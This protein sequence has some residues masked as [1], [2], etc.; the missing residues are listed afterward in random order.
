MVWKTTCHV[1]NWCLHNDIVTVV[2]ARSARL[3]SVAPDA[4]RGSATATA[5]AT[6]RSLSSPSASLS[7]P[8]LESRDSA[9]S[10]VGTRGGA[11]VAAA[12]AAAELCA[13]AR[14]LLEGALAC[15]ER[16]A[17]G[18]RARTAAAELLKV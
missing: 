18:D 9:S 10:A 16:H 6:Q 13:E 5:A 7:Q 2:A 15:F 11:A 1:R 4:A 12:A 14:G 3:L 8:S 17:R